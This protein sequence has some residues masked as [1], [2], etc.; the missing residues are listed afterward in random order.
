[1]T[2]NQHHLDTVYL[3]LEAVASI[4]MI[5]CQVYIGLDTIIL[6]M[7]LL[8]VWVLL[9]YNYHQEVGDAV[10]G[11]LFCAGGFEGWNG[12]VTN[13]GLFVNDIVRIP[14]HN[15]YSVGSLY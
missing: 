12:A 7:V 4:N 1:M 8:K 3:S 9:Y 14:G 13:L 15:D 2:I 6:R 11:D 5:V 10:L